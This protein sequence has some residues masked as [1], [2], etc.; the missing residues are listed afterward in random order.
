MLNCNYSVE[1]I[2]LTEEKVKNSDNGNIEGKKG[3]LDPVSHSLKCATPNWPLQNVVAVNPFWSLKD[4]HFE[5]IALELGLS[6]NV[7]FFMPIQFY[8]NEMHKGV[9]SKNCLLQSINE[10]SKKSILFS[11]SLDEFIQ[12]SI[13]ISEV[14]SDFKCVSELVGRDNFWN[15][16]VKNEIGKFVSM[17]F[18]DSQ[19]LST[20]ATDH[21]FF[22][23]W[24]E[25]QKYDYTLSLAG[26][27]SVKKIIDN[28]INTDPGESIIA[29]MEKLDLRSSELQSKYLQRLIVENIGCF[30][31][32]KYVEWQMELKNPV[33][34]NAKTIDLLFI[35]VLY[36]YIL[37]CHF[38][39]DEIFMD[40]WGNNKIRRHENDE[41]KIVYFSIWQKALE[42]S[43]QD[44]VVRK[45]NW[46][47]QEN[48]NYTTKAIFCIDVRSEVIRRYL[49]L[50]DPKVKTMGF[51]GFFGLPITYLKQNE[52]KGSN[53]FPV[54]I[55]A[56]YKVKEEFKTN[57]EI[58]SNL[59]EH[60]S[61]R[62]YLKSL[63][64]GSL[65]SFFYVEIFGII[66][67]ERLFRKTFLQLKNTFYHTTP[68]CFQNHTYTPSVNDIL[69]KGEN[70]HSLSELCKTLSGILSS[71]S[72][73]NHLGRLVFFIGHGSENTNN[74]FNSSLECGACG[75]HSGDINVRLM[76]KILNNPEVR[77]VLALEQRVFIPKNTL[78]VAAIHETVT[79][80]IFILDQDSIPSECSDEIKKMKETFA[81]A[82]DLTR[83]ER[84][85]FSSDCLD[86]NLERRSQNWAEVRP[87]WGLAGNASFF[88][89]PRERTLGVNLEGRS[90]LH[91]YEWKND[92]DFKI[93]ESIMTAPMIV[94]NWINMQY[95]ASTVSPEIY[96]SGSKVLHNIANENAVFEGNGGDLR[97]GL[98]FESIHDGDKF[99]HQPLR[100]SV[101]IEAPVHA[102]EHIIQTH[103][104]LKQLVENEWLFIFQIDQKE[105]R[106]RKRKDFNAM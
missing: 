8:I 9:I 14:S 92:E 10:Y 50:V 47:S 66:A 88:I 73:I 104:M 53:R 52:K 98:P 48:L 59:L 64:K 99:I 49:E 87:E 72:L 105:K 17:Y 94:T 83:A 63:R 101:F 32:F 103:E 45:L 37:F 97:I 35:K 43:Y 85:K 95:Y 21:T 34:R 75:G 65:S 78:F 71:M 29:I 23:W 13:K 70:D 96:G 54:L 15:T 74:A 57:E 12:E 79:D 18:D 82:S 46:N 33:T 84:R 16:L 22:E 60:Q 58:S 11:L 39:N 51:A 44:S 6:S 4:H 38:E 90:F 86:T 30:S 93:L 62:S 69:T 77:E 55:S 20:F 19:S 7:K 81:H 61:I 80:R 42:Y 2:S 24:F 5:D 3:E 27:R 91:E 100:L 1:E 76:A 89:A 102:I 68:V 106:V 28:F 26:I 31:Q 25:T 41:E 36:E 56:R 40:N 67:L